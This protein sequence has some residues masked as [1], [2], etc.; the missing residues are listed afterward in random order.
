MKLLKTTNLFLGV[1]RTNWFG[2]CV[3]N[4]FLRHEEFFNRDK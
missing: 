4:N 1:R 3:E 2:K